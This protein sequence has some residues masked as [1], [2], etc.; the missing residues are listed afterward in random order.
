MSDARKDMND[1]IFEFAYGEA[2]RDAIQQQ[3]YKA[4]N[5][6]ALLENERAKNIVR[7]YV[8]SI[9]DGK[10]VNPRC[11]AKKIE[12]AITEPEF[13][14]GNAQKLVNMTAKYMFFATYRNENIRSNFQQCHCPM[15]NVMI[16]KVIKE[17]EKQGISTLNEDLQKKLE[18]KHLLRDESEGETGHKWTVFLKQSWSGITGKNTEQYMLFQE[19]VRALA[20]QKA[21]IPIEY[22]FEMWSKSKQ[23]D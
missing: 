19:I 6:N 18:K 4:S 2:M 5:K 9:F 1:L 12:K 23:D 3:A 13:T 10:S 11:T 17:I 16:T 14:F 8:E 20:A 7:K 21:L 15:D 22:D